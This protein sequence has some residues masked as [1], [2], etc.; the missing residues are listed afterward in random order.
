MPRLY[1][2]APLN[3]IWEGSGNIQ[4]L[5]M[6][7][8]CAREPHSRDA[9]FDELRAA[10]GASRL[11]DAEVDALARELADLEGIEL[12][13]RRLAERLAIALQASLLLR[14][15]NMMVA[16]TFCESRLP[17]YAIPRYVDIVA[18]LPRTE[19]GKVQKFRLRKRGVGDKTWDREAAGVVLKRR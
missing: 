18:E 17:Y 11:L 3:S 15:G 6:L 2:Q 14:A 8:T 4:C 12:R 16:Q 10:R 1:R 7:R 9:V 13:A 5:D 19:N